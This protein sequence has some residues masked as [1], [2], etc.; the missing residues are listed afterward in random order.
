VSRPALRC[1]E[2]SHRRIPI[3]VDCDTG[4]DDSLALLYAA[5]SP[6]CELVAVTCTAGNV[7]A[8]Q[9]AE[10]TR[11]VLELAGRSDVEVAIGRETPLARAL[12]TTPET[13][14]PRGIGYA[15]LPPATTPLSARYRPGPDRR[16]GAP[17][18]RRADPRD[19]GPADERGPGGPARARPATPS[20]TPGDH[21]RELPIGRQHRAHDRVER[22]RRS[23]VGEDRLRGVRARK[24][25]LRATDRP[26]QRLGRRRR[27]RR[28]TTASGGAGGSA[29][30]GPQTRH[31]RPLAL[32]LDVTER[33]K[34]LPEHLA[35][36]AARAGCAPDGT[37][38]DGTNAVVRYLADALRFYMEFHSRYDG[39]YGAFIHDPLA[40][41]AALD[42]TLVGPRRS[43]WTWNWAGG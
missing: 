17:P 26:A 2:R 39:F 12:V 3:L 36:L 32:G 28:A 23:R 31:P 8:R 1:R 42:P 15:E 38:P 22:Q 7:D 18:P 25:R 6:E 37:R 13:H 9:V 21:G 35:A 20:A 11:A 19:A 33:A 16:G 43:P 40:L 5:A 27:F 30:I 24:A 10:N 4:I 14:G 41:A 34:M 29:G